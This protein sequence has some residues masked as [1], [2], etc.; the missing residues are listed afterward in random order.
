VHQELVD[1]LTEKTGLQV[2]RLD[3][4]GSLGHKEAGTEAG[5]FDVAVALGMRSF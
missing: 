4:P 3:L 1:V 5:T 2:R